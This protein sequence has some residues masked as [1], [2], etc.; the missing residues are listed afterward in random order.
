VFDFDN[1]IVHGD[2]GEATLAVLARSGVINA[3]NLPRSVCPEFS[4]PG[5]GLVRLDDSTDVT[6]Y[7]EALLNPTA[8]GTKDPTPLATGYTWA[9]EAM[10]GL[11]VSDVLDAARTAFDW[12]GPEHPGFIE[13]T[14]GRTAYPVPAFYPEMVELISELL[15]HN[16]DVWIFSASNVWSV[17]W[18]VLNR[19][20]PLLRQRG[21]RD[22]KANHVIGVST[23]L[24]D[25]KGF[26]YKDTILVRE[27]AGYANLSAASINGLRLTNRLHFPVPTYSGKIAAIMDT[28]GA[29]PFLVVGD[30][31]GDLPMLCFSR[32]RLWIARLQKPAY[33]RAALDAFRRTPF[34]SCFIQP[35][36]SLPVPG[37]IPGVRNLPK[38]PVPG[39][40][41]VRQSLRILRPLLNES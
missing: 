10:A 17:R 36:L 33:Q 24:S 31:P 21:A 25:R 30:S 15:G 5:R 32:H 9:V 7:Y 37:F 1:T 18:L 27:S 14:K 40:K 26:L 2:I 19:L 11:S 6:E 28:I 12:K 13:V 16:F 23:L 8:H 39:A 29:P 41:L 38:L 22:L 34:R 35:A 3:R 20:N 4:I